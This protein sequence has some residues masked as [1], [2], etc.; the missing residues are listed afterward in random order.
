MAAAWPESPALAAPPPAEAD[1]AEPAP[2]GAP[3]S[4]ADLVDRALSTDPATRAAWQDARAAAA[5]SGSRMAT[6]YPALDGT[7]ALTRSEGGGTLATH[8]DA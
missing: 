3:R 7:A 5:E 6:W 8:G 1:A 2:A 4:L